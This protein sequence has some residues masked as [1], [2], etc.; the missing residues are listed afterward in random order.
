LAILIS[1]FFIYNSRPA[2]TASLIIFTIIL[3][4]NN[5]TNYKKL[6]Q[7]EIVIFN[8][9]G[10]TLVALTNGKETFW[11]TSEKNMTLQGL[12]Y[13]IKPYE[14]FRGIKSSSIISLSDSSFKNRGKISYKRNFLNF[15]GI[16]L[17]VLNNI[18]FKDIDWKYYPHSD[19]IILSGKSQ[20]DQDVLLK[21]LQES[22]LIDN[23]A[24]LRFSDECSSPLIVSNKVKP[25]N[26]FLKGA[27][28]IKFKPSAEGERNIVSCG[29]FS[30][31]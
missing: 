3:S 10:K 5:I 8:V 19:I 30:H 23:R 11:L 31:N 21:F 27:V 14:G 12:N 4:Y 9:P 24:P 28:Q 2:L 18:K 13:F 22:V 25:L 7:N 17:N 29:Y 6:V 20:T 1:V 15:K 26:T 16:T